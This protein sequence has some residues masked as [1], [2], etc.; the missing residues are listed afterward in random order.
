MFDVEHFINK[1]KEVVETDE[2][3]RII[4]KLPND[5]SLKEISS[6]AGLFGGII[7]VGLKLTEKV[8]ESKVPVEIRLKFIILRILLESAQEAVKFDSKIDIKG[9]LKPIDASIT[10]NIIAELLDLDLTSKQ[11]YL[12]TIYLQNHP[13]IAKFRDHLSMVISEYNHQN[14]LNI[15][16]GQFLTEFNSIV[17]SKIEI[18]KTRYKDI[19]DLLHH[20][21]SVNDFNELQIILENAK[22]RFLSNNKYEEKAPAQYYIENSKVI[23]DKNT[24]QIKDP[25]LDKKFLQ[26]NTWT[27]QKFM[28]QR[29]FIEVIAAPFGVGK[30][31]FLKKI[32]HDLAIKYLQNPGNL[33]FYIPV[34]SEMKYGLEKTCNG[35]SLEYDLKYISHHC[36]EGNHAKV[37]VLL[38]GLDELPP[39][40][41]I[42][43]INL[44]SVLQNLKTTYP[45]IKFIISTRLE[46]GIPTRLN[47]D[48]YV[49]I[50]PFSQEQIKDFFI[51]YSPALDTKVI[52][53]IQK[54]MKF[55]K[56]LF[57]WMFAISILKSSPE[58][59]SL[60]LNMVDKDLFQITLY[61]LFIHHV[62]FGKPKE[63]ATN[64]YDLS[65]NYAKDEKKGLRLIAYL[66]NENPRISK[67]EIVQILDSLNFSFPKS[68]EVFVSTYFSVDKNER[69]IEKIE[70]FH[71]S[72]QEYLLSE[73]YIESVLNKDYERLLGSEPTNETH[74]FVHR[75][76]ESVINSRVNSNY[77]RE[78]VNSFY[79]I[80]CDVEIDDFI[81]DLRHNCVE[82]MKDEKTGFKIE[83]KISKILNRTEFRLY[84]QNDIWTAKWTALN[85]AG[86]LSRK[87]IEILD[88]TFLKSAGI[89]VRNAL[90]HL[91]NKYLAHVNLKGID[92]R[93]ADL[94]N[95]YFYGINLSF[96]K[97]QNVN[98]NGCC[99]EKGNLENVNFFGA[100]GGP[101]HSETEHHDDIMPNVFHISETVSVDFEDADLKNANLESSNFNHANFKN[102][103]F[104]NTNIFNAE[105][106]Q[107]EFT[108]DK[109]DGLCI[110]DHKLTG[111][112]LKQFLSDRITHRYDWLKSTQRRI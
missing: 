30:S 14:E 111:E 70:F 51:K 31:T 13:V 78:I 77:L 74:L 84:E 29:K 85:I 75:I 95:A 6:N 68:A 87:Y 106:R 66:K 33:A 27:I 69:G 80:N 97:L 19:E 36:S 26:E 94:N 34:I 5:P 93:G 82:F 46:S 90:P 49:R 45:N 92:L 12:E 22:K 17:R 101:Y 7:K 71:K 25:Y 86:Y 1:L 81:E 60:L 53:L 88:E 35:N 63:I 9:L 76:M 112:E 107:A 18:E 20:L 42:N 83:E 67:H 38:D 15:N 57:C 24:W 59:G 72:F 43:I 104:S 16:T 37:L 102:A 65:Y 28:E 3:I 64:E 109:L 54:D 41:P 44:F 58:N 61:Q 100:F 10:E 2:I 96:G 11:E 98:M 105:L 40:R 62:I 48:S 8:Y 32:A 47:L 103:I 56:P 91:K 4:E 110:L 79:E 73:F 23:M 89:I 21:K 55:S 108:V 39:D 52:E 99:M 50:L